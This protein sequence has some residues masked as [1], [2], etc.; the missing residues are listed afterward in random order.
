MS[1]SWRIL[2]ALVAVFALVASAC[3]ND[4]DDAPVSE[5]APAATEDEPAPAP[6]PDDE[7]EPAPAPEPDDE[8]EP[9]PAPEPDDEDEP[10]PAPEPEEPSDPSIV[11][12]GGG[13]VI[14]IGE[15]PDEWDNYAGVTDTEIRFGSSLP[16]VGRASRIRHHRRWRRAL[17]RRGRSH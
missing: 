11:E 7:D 16:P 17:L 15:C 1:K 8:D 6:E 13:A 4:D 9:A 3:G 2:L 10:A 5:P 14:D 12:L